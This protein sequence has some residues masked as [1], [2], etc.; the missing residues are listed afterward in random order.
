MRNKRYYK[1]NKITRRRAYHRPFSLRAFLD[2][3]VLIKKINYGF[4]QKR[5]KFHILGIILSFFL[6]IYVYLLIEYFQFK[7][8]GR[9]FSFIGDNGGAV[10]FSLV[11]LYG[12]YIF[13]YMIFKRGFLAGSLFG[14]ICLSLGVANYYKLALRSEN[15][16]PWETFTQLGNIGALSDFVKIGFPLWYSLLIA[17]GLGMLVILFISKTSLP[18]KIIPRFILAGVIAL[19]MYISVCSQGMI[20]RTLEIYNMSVAQT[21]NQDKNHSEN[22]FVGGFLLNML[23]MDMEAPDEYSKKNIEKIIDKYDGERGKDFFSPD[24]IVVLSESFWDPKLLPETTFSKNPLGNFDEI[25]SREN[26]I[27]GYMYQTAF[28]GGT[29]RTEFEVITGL[30]CDEIPAGAVPWQYVDEE[31]PTYASAF[32]KIGYNTTFLHTYT[33]DFYLREDTYPLLG[34]DKAYF[35]DDLEKIGEVPRKY[36]GFYISDDSFAEYIKYTLNE[37]PNKP[38]FIFGISMENHQPYTNK[39]SSFEVEVKNPKISQGTMEEIKHYATGVY[40]SDKALGKLAELVDNRDKETILI[41]FGDHLPNLGENK[42][43]YRESGFIEKGEMSDE[44]WEKILRTPFLIYSNFPME[45]GEILKKGKENLISSYSLLTGASELMGA[46]KTP[47]MEFLSDY[48]EAI[49]YYNARLKI[50][51]NKIQKRYINGHK[52]ITYDLI[53]GEKYIKELNSR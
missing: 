32:K 43:A 22:G 50:E 39:Y 3:Y 19:S 8:M 7:N 30:S 9:L 13:L 15:I 47:F 2:K 29:V 21:A 16:Y 6:P 48:N 24:I 53:H 27:S 14:V 37:N 5:A 42:G 11:A 1:P 34:F 52:L 45:E 17:L 51:P 31:I 10:A 35:E 23:T 33:S 4:G 20:E 25:A 36:N 46:P 41:F 40:N 44:D 28:A 12:L 18:I 49:P 26:A 38:N